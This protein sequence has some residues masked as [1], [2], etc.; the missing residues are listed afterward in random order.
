VILEA[1]PEER[2]IMRRPPRDP[3]SHLLSRRL[4]SWSLLQGALALAVMTGLLVAALQRGMEHEEIRALIFVMLVGMNIVLIFVNRTFSASLASAFVRPNRLLSVGLGVVAVILA[5]IFGWPA[6]RGFFDLGPLQV[7][8]LA[9]G[10]AALVLALL[11]LQ[12]S[13]LGWRGRL[14]S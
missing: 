10:A 14:E 5:L 13:R 3:R 9:M 12:L 4:V 11:V 6:A 2:D 7:D 1:E 8:D